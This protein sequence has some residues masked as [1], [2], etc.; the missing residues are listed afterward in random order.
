MTLSVG[1]NKG[2]TSLYIHG[3]CKCIYLLINT[4]GHSIHAWPCNCTMS[5][6]YF[7]QSIMYQGPAYSLPESTQGIICVVHREYTFIHM[8]ELAT[9]IYNWLITFLKSNY[10]KALS[11]TASSC[12]DLEDAR[13][14]KKNERFCM[15][16]PHDAL[17][18]RSLEVVIIH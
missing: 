12:T 18:H 15:F 11:C 17:T 3:G 10:S 5:A 6:V 9:F 7:V 14:W 16:L 4:S 8:T 2:P 13:F 1:S